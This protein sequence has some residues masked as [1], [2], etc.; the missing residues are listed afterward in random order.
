MTI[1]IG[2]LKRGA[3]D[4]NVQV[5]G[6]QLTITPGSQTGTFRVDV[7][8]SD[9]MATTS[10]NFDV[11]V[12]NHAPTLSLD[13]QVVVAGSTL[14][15]PL[16]ATDE[17]GHAITYSVELLGDQLSILDAEHGFWSDGNYYTNYL[18][19]NERWI[20]DVA[21]QWHY[22]L[23]D[24]HLYRWPGE[25]RNQFVD[26]RIGHGHLRGSV[27]ADRSTT[28]AGQRHHPKWRLDD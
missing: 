11:E 20:R 21:N 28:G 22:L 4:L 27:T 8:V 16:P 14:E 13:D 26:R 18:G 23:P 9:G 3:P 12:L 15:I 5:V 6:N 1:P 25:F 24:G 2:C 10:T 17:D 7:T 19:Q